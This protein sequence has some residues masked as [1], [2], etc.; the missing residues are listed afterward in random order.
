M[1]K[2]AELREE[3]DWGRTVF[4]RARV[5]QHAATGV[6][7]PLVPSSSKRELRSSPC[8]PLRAGPLRA[9]ERRLGRR[10]EDIRLP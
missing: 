4:P 7:A 2:T 9:L 3:D 5:S 8:P 10:L 1:R 6:I